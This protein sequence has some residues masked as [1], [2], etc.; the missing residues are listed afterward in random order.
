MRGVGRRRTLR[1]AIAAAIAGTVAFAA[2][3]AAG[4]GGGGTGDGGRDIKVMTQNMY[5][6]ASLDDA[7]RTGTTG[8]ITGFLRAVNVIYHTLPLTD[9][10]TRAKELAAEIAAEHPD[11]I[12][13]QE[14]SNWTFTRADG[15]AF[16]DP[17]DFLAILESDLADLN[18]PQLD[19]VEKAVSPN[20]DLR[21]PL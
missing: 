12:G 1:V 10:Q 19:Y 16:A 9:F 20:A 3:S 7:V 2:P 17:I 18:D 14:V 13:L 4:A 11:V 21:A 6:G 8:D 5:L 15:T